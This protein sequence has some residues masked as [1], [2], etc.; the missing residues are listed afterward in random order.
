M[1]EGRVVRWGFPDR[2]VV[3]RARVKGEA[4]LSLERNR[5]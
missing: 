1:N 5:D 3:K 2:A 4:W